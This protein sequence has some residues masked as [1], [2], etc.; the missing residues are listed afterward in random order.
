MT[1]T[2]S[3]IQASAGA[4]NTHSDVTKAA[5]NFQTPDKVKPD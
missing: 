3:F 5:D 4:P 2:G 1:K